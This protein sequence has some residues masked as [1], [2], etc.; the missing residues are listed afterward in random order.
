MDAEAGTLRETGMPLYV[1][2]LERYGDV[3][4]VPSSSI[5][6]LLGTNCAAPDIQRDEVRSLLVEPKAELEA[7]ENDITTLQ[8]RLADY[9]RRKRELVSYVEDL[10]AL[11]SPIRRMPPEIM[12]RIF[13]FCGDIGARGP[14]AEPSKRAPLLLGSVCRSWRALS[15]AIPRLWTTLYLRLPT[16]GTFVK[17]EEILRAWL[18]RSRL[19]PVSLWLWNDFLTDDMPV[20]FL[21]K[22]SDII[23]ENSDRWK[24]IFIHFP[25]YDQDWESFDALV[26]CHFPN[27]EE[28]EISPQF[29]PWEPFKPELFPKLRELQVPA[30]SMPNS[31][32]TLPWTQLTH[33]TLRGGYR[34]TN[35]E[36][37]LQI[38]SCA[39]LLSYLHVEISQYRSER[40]W[41]E[42]FDRITM[43]SLH[44]LVL[45]TITSHEEC[46]NHF[47]DALILPH[48]RDF[49]LLTRVW[50]CSRMATAWCHDSFLSLLLR[51]KCSINHFTLH[52]S[53]ITGAQLR[54]IMEQCPSLVLLKLHGAK[55][56]LVLSEV[57][58]DMIYDPS[59]GALSSPQSSPTLSSSSLPQQEKASLPLAPWLKALSLSCESM[60]ALTHQID[61]SGLTFE[62]AFSRMVKS[63]TVL[64]S[65]DSKVLQ[66]KW[67]HWTIWWEW[68][69]GFG[70]SPICAHPD[71]ALEN[72]LNE[73]CADEVDVG[74]SAA[75]YNKYKRV[76]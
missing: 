76:S 6:R 55:T 43:P 30:G 33:L 36:E 25:A 35:I 52:A 42:Q 64:R 2:K 53:N 29:T 34:T 23:A 18:E 50:D 41:D 47:M 68:Y 63:R 15:F 4:E 72:R 32:K 74:V 21:R 26:R 27:L 46:I 10:D 75:T 38:L 5:L 58:K 16:G 12:S 24:A 70:T 20:S 45:V 9:E 1:N 54:E 73:L 71:P 48:L 19:F 39:P 13:E 61:P 59:C 65:R 11:L 17:Q 40:K 3:R 57:I 8:A 69:R 62:E 66:L 28:L 44:T 51:S 56:H 31:H 14:H 22:L 37:L 67:I 60:D 7:V 49:Q